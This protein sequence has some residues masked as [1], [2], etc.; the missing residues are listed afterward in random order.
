ME[1]CHQIGTKLL[2][3]L[4]QKNSSDDPRVPLNYRGISLLS[5]VYKMYSSVLNNRLMKFCCLNDTLVDEQNGFRPR[6]SCLDHLYVL[7]TIIRT[8]KSTSQSTF[9]AFVDMKKAFDWTNHELLFYKLL[10]NLT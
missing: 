2:L 1:L 8:R 4:Y 6:R 3:F 10:N 5:N 9:T 7:T